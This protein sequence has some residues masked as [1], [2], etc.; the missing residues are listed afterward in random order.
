MAPVAG[1]P[2][3]QYQLD[4][5]IG[6]GLTHFILSVGYRAEMISDYFGA[7]YRGAELS[8]VVEERPLGTGGG[9]LLAAEELDQDRPFLLLNGDTYFEVDCGRLHAF[10][11]EQ[12]ADWCFSLFR[13]R[14]AGRYMG[15]EITEQGR[16]VSFSGGGQ[17]ERL[18]N[19]GVYWVRPKALQSFDRKAGEPVSLEEDVFPQILRRGQ[20]LFGLESSGRF[21]DIGLPSD[22]HRAATILIG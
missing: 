4:Y 9:L 13:T 11:Q 19:G 16:I 7:T 22:Y 15:L 6:Q 10:S 21:I 8:Y 14:E 20:R 17:S 18:A 5:W 2:F 1:R 12:K 3:L